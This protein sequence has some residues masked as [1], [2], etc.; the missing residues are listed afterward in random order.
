M[1]NT[2]RTTQ[3]RMLRWIVGVGRRK[4]QATSKE[5]ESDTRSDSNMD[6][7]EEP[8]EHDSG[9]ELEGES[10]VEWIQRATNIAEEHLAKLKID[11]WV[12]GH[13][14]RKFRWAGHVARRQDDRWAVQ[15]LEWK[16]VDGRRNPWRPK[17][18]WTDDL[19]EYFGTLGVHRFDWWS[20]AQ[21][22]SIWREL[23]HEFVNIF[24]SR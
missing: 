2:L 19:T 4:A 1:Q 16:S 10:F 24:K 7:E 14:R 3:R 18:R 11:D 20:L 23:E 5:S 17:R 6:G 8:D 12:S 15:S 22:R 9:E 13:R 21:D